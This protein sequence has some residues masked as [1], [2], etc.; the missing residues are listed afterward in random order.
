MAIILSGSTIQVS[1]GIAT[2]TVTS[3]TS[4]TLTNTS[5]NFT[6]RADR[7]VYITGGTGAGQSRGIRSVNTTTL[8][9]W[10]T[11]DIIPDTTSTYTISHD[12]TDLT[13][14]AGA[15]YVG[16]ST[17]K[18]VQYLTGNI[19][20]LSNGVF[21]GLRNTIILGEGFRPLV[22]AGG[23][24]QFGYQLGDEGVQGGAIFMTKQ[25]GGYLDWTMSGRTRLYGTDWVVNMQSGTGE[26]TRVNQPSNPQEFTAIGCRFQDIIPH[27]SA[28]TT[29]V[30][31]TFH[32][33]RG[34]FFTKSKPVRSS[35][36]KVYSGLLSIRT[37][38]GDPNGVD[39]FDL[40]YL[41]ENPNFSIFTA[42]VFFFGYNLPDGV[43]YYW[44]TG[45]PSGF[46]SAFLWFSNVGDG[47]I[48][49]GYSVKP[50]VRNAAGAALANVNLALIDKDGNA[51]W[52][53][54]KSGTFDPVKTL[55]LVTD[56]NGTI[57]SAIGTNENGLVVRS[58]WSRLNATTS[59]A[60]SYFPFTLRARRYGYSFLSKSV[61]YVARTEESLGLAV[62]VLVTETNAATVAAYTTLET[63]AKFY[64]YSQYWL[65][66]A[67]NMTVAETITRSGALIDAGSYNVTI[68]ATAASVWSVSG[69]TITIKASTFTGDMTTTGIITLANGATF[70]GT[71]TD[72]NGTITPPKVVSITGITA[73]SRLQIYNVTTATEIV[74]TV[75]AGTTYS[76][77]YE[78]G[79]GYSQGDTV[80]VR[81][82]YQNGTTAKL[83]F[84]AQAVV[85]TSGWSILAAQQ[86]DTVYSSLGIDGATITEFTPD[87]PNVQVDISDL[88][89]T[90][91]VD[92]LYAWFVHTQASDEDGI[93]LWFNGIVPEDDANFRIITSIL[94]FKIDNTAATG[95]TF[96]DGRRLYRD[97]NASPLVQSTTGGGSITLF[98]GKVYTSVVST[99][100]LVITGD[101]SQVP[102][103]VQSGMTAQGYTEEKINSI[104]NNTNLIPAT[105]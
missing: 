1:S 73:G 38:E 71:R 49:E 81:L 90:T 92:R 37:T 103:A 53:T 4:N 59:Q 36:N 96:I 22:V 31:C 32:G 86:D 17:S 46:A 45:F 84:S 54:S 19:E 39:F 57:A 3:A 14:I 11:W 34:G 105:L 65:S 21:G 93:R 7:I 29:I 91:R 80:R 2:G 101:I 33:P 89:G 35:G 85:G 28:T 62:N 48:Y 104:Q 5:A 97:D 52:T 40:T 51:G 24:W 76:A 50:V 83:P 70:I 82:A 68:D 18:T 87:F 100:S 8:T 94:N 69:N 10:G 99:S 43:S 26:L 20:V 98:A 95:V 30:N 6:G 13:A 77:T 63:S 42:P 75:V 41:G 102:A 88:D 60:T 56:A 64:D 16:P 25:G 61:D 72:A 9:I 12:V 15:T 23:L 44:N 67:A 27:E 58:V 74:N 79:T 55:N 78:E 66:L 47:V